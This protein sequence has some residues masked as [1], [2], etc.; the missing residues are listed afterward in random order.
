MKEDSRSRLLVFVAHCILN[1]NAVVKELAVAKGILK[2]VVDALAELGVGLIQLPCPETGH[3]G[4]KRF[5]HTRE[6]YDSVGFRRYCYY[7]AEEAVNTALEYENNGYKVLA[8]IGIR[9]S[10]SCGVTQTTTGWLGGDPRKAG[11]YN[12]V[13][14]AG[15]FMEILREVFES[16]GLKPAMTDVDVNRLKESA[17]ELRRFL[18]DLICRK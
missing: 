8:V 12:R 3:A 1:Q 4:L 17:T 16:Y 15:V 9:G 6:Q 5:W 18:G 7:L 11:E 14:G 2:E 13:E 10:P